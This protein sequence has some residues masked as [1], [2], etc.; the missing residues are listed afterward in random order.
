MENLLLKFKEDSH[1]IKFIHNEL[2]GSKATFK[3]VFCLCSVNGFAV[4]IDHY[5]GLAR[6]KQNLINLKILI[7]LTFNIALLGLWTI[8]YSGSGSMLIV[9]SGIFFSIPCFT[10]IN[11]NILKQAQIL[12]VGIMMNGVNRDFQFNKAGSKSASIVEFGS[13]IRR[14]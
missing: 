8:Q 7:V 6:W 10:I 5:N 4:V 9:F 13:K 12:A 11:K 2:F 3:K 1:E 14:G